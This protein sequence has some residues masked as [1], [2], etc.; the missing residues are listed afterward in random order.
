MRLAVKAPVLNRAV[1]DTNFLWSAGGA[2]Y[3]QRRAIPPRLIHILF[4][5]A[6]NR[7]RGGRDSARVMDAQDFRPS[8]RQRNGRRPGKVSRGSLLRDKCV[9]EAGRREFRR[10]SELQIAW[11]QL[12]RRAPRVAFHPSGGATGFLR[13]EHASRH[14]KSHTNRQVEE[15]HLQRPTFC[16]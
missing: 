2:A 8:D 5:A 16:S 3:S 9:T 1:I 11:E 12:L 4:D 13:N 15:P 7:D 14:S 6:R 10:Y